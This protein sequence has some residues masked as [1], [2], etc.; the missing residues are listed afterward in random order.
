[1]S[2]RSTAKQATLPPSQEDKQGWQETSMN[3]D[4]AKEHLRASRAW[5]GL[6][7]GE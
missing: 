7:Y 2:E 6:A 1:V 5:Q 4:D 3:E